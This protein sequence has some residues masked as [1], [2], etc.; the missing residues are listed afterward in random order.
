MTAKCNA[1]IF[2]AMNKQI[3]LL[4]SFTCHKTILK[5]KSNYIN[6]SVTILPKSLYK[7]YKANNSQLSQFGL[8][9]LIIRQSRQN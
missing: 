3:L 6:V 2:L 5:S 7:M 9:K 1:L 8:I 4:K